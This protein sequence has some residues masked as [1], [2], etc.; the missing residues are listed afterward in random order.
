MVQKLALLFFGLIAL[1]AIGGIVLELRDTVTGQYYAYGGGRWHT[2]TQIVQLE[3]DEACI[4]SGFEPVYPVRVESNKYGTLV[5]ICKSG[6]QYVSV[7]V[8]QTI[9]V[10]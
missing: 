3:P 8:I 5:S 10:P 2:G 9:Y 6:D 1:V 7:P 4:Y